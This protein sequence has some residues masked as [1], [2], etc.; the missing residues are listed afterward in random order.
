MSNTDLLHMHDFDIEACDT[1]VI[2]VAPT[3]DERTDIILDQTCFYARDGGQDWHKGTIRKGGIEFTVE[4]VRLDEN[5][6]VHHIGQVAKGSFVEG[7]TVHCQVD[8]ERH[9]INM[10]LHSADHVI[11]MAVDQLGLDWIGMKG[12]H[13]PHTP[14][15]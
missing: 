12:Q 13:Y 3:E 9:F 15:L 1:K 7:D 14:L 5:G 8:H 4:E 6:V 11:D 2:S 10:C